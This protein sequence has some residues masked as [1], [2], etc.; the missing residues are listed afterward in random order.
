MTG[1]YLCN[2]A[3]A[4]QNLQRLDQLLYRACAIVEKAEGRHLMNQGMLQQLKSLR[5]EM[6][7]G[8]YLLGSL[9][10][11]AIEDKASAEEVPRALLRFVEI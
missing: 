3:T 10:Y 11:R 4:E 8:F 5:D 9:R 7:K 6:L 2:Q 1:K